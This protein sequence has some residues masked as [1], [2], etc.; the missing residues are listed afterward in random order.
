[1]WSAFPPYHIKT[2]GNAA[3][4]AGEATHTKEG[5]RRM[6]GE[7]VR[8]D[9][10]RLERTIVLYYFRAFERKCQDLVDDSKQEIKSPYGHSLAP[11]RGIDAS[12]EYLP[13]T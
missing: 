12:A 6:E 4:A 7:G 3:A 10:H 1:M 8:H 2:E 9:C 5:A 11:H 13:L